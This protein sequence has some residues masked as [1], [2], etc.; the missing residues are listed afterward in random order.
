MLMATSLVS[1][2]FDQNMTMKQ[3]GLLAIYVFFRAKRYVDGVGGNTDVLFIGDWGLTRIPTSDVQRIEAWWM[4][5]EQAAIAFVDAL[6]GPK[7]I[8][9]SKLVTLAEF[10]DS[11][12]FYDE[13]Y[14]KADRVLNPASKPEPG[15]MATR[16]FPVGN[17]EFIQY[18]GVSP[19]MPSDDQKSEPKP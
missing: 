11:I 8:D 12:A 14:R 19:P 16:T 1:E 2:L 6:T 17:T 10:K 5:V 7:Q 13:V 4:E 18:E 3:A 15:M 9:K